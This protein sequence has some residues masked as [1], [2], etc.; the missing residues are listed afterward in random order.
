MS[1]AIPSSEMWL[2]IRGPKPAIVR[3]A[4][5]PL[6]IER[7]ADGTTPQ[8][9]TT[10]RTVPDATTHPLVGAEVYL[11]SAHTGKDA[12]NL[13]ATWPQPDERAADARPGVERRQGVTVP[14]WGTGGADDEARITCRRCHP[15]AAHTHATRSHTPLTDRCI[16]I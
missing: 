15:Y 1:S 8:A 2:D 11:P 12:V 3:A 7:L 13:P 5:D 6:G 16:D 14:V 10:Q 9:P 4:L